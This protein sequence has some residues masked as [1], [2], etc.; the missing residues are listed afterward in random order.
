MI[1]GEWVRM[2]ATR[3]RDPVKAAA[4]LHAGLVQDEP[5]I[6][7]F[8]CATT[9]DLDALGAALHAA[10]GDTPLVGC[11]TAG[12]LTPLGYLEGSI[13]GVSIAR[14]QISV[15]IGRLDALASFRLAD[16]E[17]L[18][19]ELREQLAEAGAPSGPA[20]T[21]G[22]LMI[23]GLS[24]QEEAV[25]SALARPL[26]GTPLVG[27]SAGDGTRFGATFVYHEGRFHRDAAVFVLASTDLPIVAFKTQHFVRCADKMVVTGADPGRRVVTEINGAP[28][29]REYARAVGLDV[30][31]LTPL[32]FASHPVVVR[33]GG[34][35][36]VRSIQKVNDDGSLTFFCAIDEGIV[37]TVA[38]GQDLVA[39]L[40]AALADI[41]DQIGAP[42]VVLGCDCVLRRL[43]IEQRAIKEEISNILVESRVVGFA[44]Y[45][46]QFNAMHVN[47]TFTGIAIG[48]PGA[49]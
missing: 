34:S 31:S 43:E 19:R 30:K 6:T 42:A 28:A 32:I 5:A 26:C 13:T 10:F 8:W 22:Y 33:V 4:V 49:R 7:L 17:R 41:H 11:T 21:F 25:V 20:R 12:E 37:L 38:R 39:N 27:G 36:Y 29:G 40:K 45:G 18:V 3:E 44:T 15:A 9:Y 16:A 24:N 23:D 35:E 1:D 2:A 47:Q 48:R 14:S 46:E